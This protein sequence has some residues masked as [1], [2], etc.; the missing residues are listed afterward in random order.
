[1]NRKAATFGTTVLGSGKTKNNEEVGI[2]F[3][4]KDQFLIL[5]ADNFKLTVRYSDESLS[6][7]EELHLIRTIDSLSQEVLKFNDEIF[8]RRQA[9]EPVLVRRIT[10]Y[11]DNGNISM[12]GTTASTSDH[13]EIKYDFE[14]RA[15]IATKTSNMSME[16]PKDKTRSNTHVKY[17]IKA[18]SIFDD[19]SKID[20]R[21][22]ATSKLIHRYHS[23]IDV[24]EDVSYQEKRIYTYEDSEVKYTL[25]TLSVGDHFIYSLSEQ[26]KGSNPT[27][28]IETHAAKKDKN[29]I[30]LG[31]GQTKFILVL[32]KINDVTY[33]VKVKK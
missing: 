26:V 12:N 30:T 28:L 19:M 33:L 11:Y 27:N 4:S 20:P 9:S 7:I 23:D 13:I 31:S 24:I 6:S 22:I 10:Y 3:N 17:E 32:K 29:H 1:M 14:S 25:E 8:Y 2:S 21:N 16:N 15:F 18:R 5:S